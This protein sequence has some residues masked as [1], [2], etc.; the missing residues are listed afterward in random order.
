[1]RSLR[2]SALAVVTLLSSAVVADEPQRVSVVVGHLLPEEGGVKP[3]EPGPLRSPFGVDFDAAGNMFI[4]ELEGGRAHRLG[5][6]GEFTTI[7]GD[8][9]KGYRG[10]G[11][12][13]RKAVFNGMHNVAVTPEGEVYIADSWNNCVRRIDPK[14]GVIT[15]FAG[16]GRAGFSGD[17]GPAKEAT[18]DYVM[19]VTLDPSNERLHLADLRNR[20][21]RVIDLETGT[22]R[23]VAGNGKRGVPKDGAVATESPLVD[24]RAVAA[25]SKGRVYILERSG[26]ALRVVTPDGKIRT[27]AG[28]GKP[29]DRDGSGR[30]AGFRSPKHLCIDS[31]DNVLIADDGNALIRKYDPRSETVTTVLGRGQGK[32]AVTLKRPHGVCFEN[33]VLYVVDSGHDR[34]LKIEDRRA[35]D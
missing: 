28:T 21:I 8:G 13:A 16:T 27:V 24:P 5:A 18:F 35:R 12:P 3:A 32:P 30:E 4:V 29:G 22:L 1:M 23:T 10:D 31:E 34:I 20:R 14:S 25:D 2:L 6:D 11:G 19:C 15:T 17:G 26:H 7:A 33:G 9:T